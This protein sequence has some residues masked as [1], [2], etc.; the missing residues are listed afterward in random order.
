MTNTVPLSRGGR[1]KGSTDK[2][3][4]QKTKIFRE[5]ITEQDVVDVANRL[6]DIIR[7]E[8]S[9]PSDIAKVAPIILRHTI[10]TADV[11]AVLEKDREALTPEQADVLRSLIQLE[12]RSH[13]S[14][15]TIV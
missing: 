12:G 5:A 9:T 4:I 13:R 11:D 10:N 14:K 8:A 1:P 3:I 7:D 15:L 6:M 2:T